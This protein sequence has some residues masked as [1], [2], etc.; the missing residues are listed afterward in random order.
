[1]S[2][3]LIPAIIQ[4]AHTN[5]VLMLGYMNEEALN[6]TKAEGKVTFFSRSRQR[7]WTK[8]ETSGNFLQLVSLQEDC[9]NDTYLVRVLPEGKTCHTGTY[10]CFGE[11]EPAGFLHELQAVI[12]DR[13][14]HP[15]KD[16]YTA[17][18]F[19]KGTKKIAQKLGEE[20]TEVILEAMDNRKDLLVEESS[21]LLYHFLVLLADQGLKL[22]DVEAKLME[23]HL[24]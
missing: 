23:R 7:L 19:A 6:K 24:K 16:S 5:Q 13:K 21:D 8:G 2:E 20:A 22:E 4:H 10:T 17:S 9:D 12:R 11:K 3:Q 18:L 15:D 14:K 1:M